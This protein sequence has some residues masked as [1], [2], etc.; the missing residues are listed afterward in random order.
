M[1]SKRLLLAAV[2]CVGC[3][4]G[5]TTRPDG[6]IASATTKVGPPKGSLIVVGGGG[7]GPEVMA[8]FIELAGGPDALIVT[9]PTAG[10]AETYP[11][12]AGVAAW[13]NAGAK[14]VVSFHTKDRKVADS[15]KFVEVLKK[16]GGVWFSGG[17]HFHLVDAYLGTKTEYEF[18]QVLARGGVVGGSSAGASILGSFLVR[19]APSNNNMIMAHPQYLKGF[20]Y[21]RGTGI[22]QHVVARDRLADLADSLAGKYPDTLFI[23]EDEGTVWVVQGDQAEIIGR[24]KAFVYNGKDKTDSGKP[25]LTLFPGDRYDLASRHVIRRAIDD[26]PLSIKDVDAVFAGFQKAGGP[27]AQIVVAQRGKVYVSKAYN[28]PIQRKFV[29]ETSAPNFALGEVGDALRASV[30]LASMRP[31][32]GGRG[33]RGGAATEDSTPVLPRAQGPL[34]LTAKLVSGTSVRDYLSHASDVRNGAKEFADLVAKQAN[35]TFTQIVN[36]RIGTP[37]GMQRV[38]ADSTGAIVA[39]VDALYRFEQGLNSNRSFTTV[40]ALNIFTPIG[41]GSTGNALGWRI[42]SYK[43]S[44]RQA[45]YGTKDGKRNAFVRFPEQGAAIIILTNDENAD[46]R[47][48]A[49]QIADRLFRK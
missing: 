49:E 9:V 37:V 31:N 18:N 23:S 28:I 17:R 2:A 40:D 41:G 48:M 7:Q 36:T 20:A 33:G 8:K 47:G 1:N 22:D 35:S 11:S 12:D 21:L 19:G 10:G 34:A 24:N 14:N 32:T 46:A 38:V 13:R 25:F 4:S 16:A 43:G 3:S 15:D 6:T 44:V 29:P 27:Q 45:A 42:D 26:S 39:S 30:F 5:T